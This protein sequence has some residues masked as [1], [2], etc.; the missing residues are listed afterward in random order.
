MA[1]KPNVERIYPLSPMQQGMLFESLFDGDSG[2][3]VT[4]LVLSLR[5]LDVLKLRS[6]WDQVFEHHEILRTSFV[7][8]SPT[9]PLQVVRSELCLP[10]T[11]LDWRGVTSGDRLAGLNAFL[12]ADRKRGFDLR[13]APLMRLTLIC[14]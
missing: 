3:Y 1:R 14:T 11:E 10:W 13:A 5:N 4:Q 2:V 7:W 8:K 12:D 9:T 6:A